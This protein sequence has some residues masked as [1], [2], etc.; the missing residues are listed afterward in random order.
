MD[1]IEQLAVSVGDAIS[2]FYLLVWGKGEI[3]AQ[4]S[5]FC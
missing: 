4:F 1:V 2:D 5:V 3:E